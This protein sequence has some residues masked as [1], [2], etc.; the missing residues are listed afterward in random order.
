[1][2]LLLQLFLRE[3]NLHGCLLTEVSECRAWLREKHHTGFVLITALN[4]FNFSYPYYLDL[5]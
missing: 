1:M 3:G 2:L 5:G 4:D